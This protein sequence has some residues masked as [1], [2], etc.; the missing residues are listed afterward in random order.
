MNDPGRRDAEIEGL[1]A[2]LLTRYEELNLLYRLSADLS[3]TFDVVTLAQIALGRA[4]EVLG[5][6]ESGVVLHDPGGVRLVAAHNEPPVPVGEYLPPGE[7]IAEE[8]IRTGRPIVRDAEDDDPTPTRVRRPGQPS[9]SV[10]LLPAAGDG[11]AFG[12]I[13]LLRPVGGPK[14]TASDLQLAQ[15]IAS[16]LASRI[17]ASRHVDELQEAAQAEREVELAATVQRSLLPT[18]PET[19][20]GLQVTA[21]SIPAARVGGDLYDLVVDSR[22]AV[23]LLVAD[24]LG[25]GF[26]SAVTMAS[27][28][29]VLR[30]EMRERD[31][32][33]AALESANDT[34]YADLVRAE[35][36]VT[37]FCARW[38]PANQ[39]LV[40]ANA[41]HNPALVR[42]A[43]G[44]VEELDA[45]G[46]P[47][48]L[49]DRARYSETVTA[50][51]QGDTMLLY[52]DG[53]VEARGES[54]ELFGDERLKAIV[55]SS[56][57]PGELT[58]LILSAVD[59]H[60]AGGPRPDDV[61]MLAVAPA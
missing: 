44:I 26:A 12:S 55:A 40:V 6:S 34:L 21:R 28:R 2:E 61:T 11:A 48:G 5:S 19:V 32:P 56:E 31:S 36:L 9:L 27:V 29:A 59:L 3:G 39:Y 57:S 42:R 30:R 37:A 16:Q 58:D 14:F 8:V 47:L 7:T 13:S 10:P 51:R 50:L 25:H 17:E 54:G 20:R 22:G 18:L 33:A 49:L 41:A 46:T 15:A 53:V 45:D 60:L 38:D 23:W 35:Q 4:I 43:S 52:T 1:Q 24:V